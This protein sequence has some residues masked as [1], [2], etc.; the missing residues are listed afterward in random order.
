M[1][2]YQSCNIQEKEWSLDAMIA[3]LLMSRLSTQTQI[4][5]IG[6][7]A[8]ILGQK[9]LTRTTAGEK[10]GGGGEISRRRPIIEVGYSILIDT[11]EANAS[12]Y[13]TPSPCHTP[14]AAVMQRQCYSV[15]GCLI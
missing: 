1:E 12:N 14:T 10:G 4:I 5:D 13:H 15:S 6:G 9:L 2:V 11:W 7:S 3:K 8:F